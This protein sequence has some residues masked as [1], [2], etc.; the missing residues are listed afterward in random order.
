MD[1]EERD[2]LVVEEG[3]EEPW[4]RCI[5]Y[6]RRVKICLDTSPPPRKKTL[7]LSPYMSFHI[8]WVG[9][10]P[11]GIFPAVSVESLR[12]GFNDIDFFIN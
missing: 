3:E 4:S 11:Q 2:R 6:E 12:L 5:M 1:L 8:C 10:C 7:Y 9:G